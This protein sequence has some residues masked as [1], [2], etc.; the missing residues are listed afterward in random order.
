MSSTP[1]VP[2]ANPPLSSEERAAVDSL[3][4]NELESIDACILSHCS[5]RFLKVARI[6]SRT[7]R[8]L[9]ERF[10]K[11]SYIFYTL[12]LQHL[13]D[14]GYLDAAGNLSFMRFSEVRLAHQK[15]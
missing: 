11:L 5:D 10:P 4:E 13:V 1:E 12:R 2:I 3:T 6:M 9:G 14:A 15:T 8:E 7:E